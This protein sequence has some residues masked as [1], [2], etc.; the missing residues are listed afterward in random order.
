MYICRRV[1]FEFPRGKKE[2]ERKREG[3]IAQCAHVS[4]LV[5]AKRRSLY[6]CP[7]PHYICVCIRDIMILRAH[8][9]GVVYAER[10]RRVCNYRIYLV[11]SAFLERVA[12]LKHES[13]ER[14]AF[15]F[16]NSIG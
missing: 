15:P 13:R 9:V 2:I 11:C 6:C 7:P 1:K 12:T 4:G 8:T 14:D 3:E 16:L 10:D 5:F